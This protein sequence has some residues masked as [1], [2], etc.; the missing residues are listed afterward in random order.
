M[1][2]VGSRR[3]PWPKA[4]SRSAA[5]FQRDDADERSPNDAQTGRAASGR[6]ARGFESNPAD[7]GAAQCR[8]TDRQAIAARRF[9]VDAAGPCADE[10]TGSLSRAGETFGR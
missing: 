9:A 3:P 7:D 2:T 8:L 1:E 6:S 5:S 10:R 4:A